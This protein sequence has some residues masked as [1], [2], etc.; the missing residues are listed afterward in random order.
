MQQI[1]RLASALSSPAI[2]IVVVWCTLLT[3]IAIGP[4]DYPGQPS[5]AALALVAAGVSL[6]I[7]GH[8][9]GAWC[10]GSWFTRQATFLRRRCGV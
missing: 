1:S 2:L 7:L 8:S 3:C 9:V 5:T 10:F 4:I 6:F